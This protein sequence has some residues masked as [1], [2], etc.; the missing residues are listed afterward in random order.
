MTETEQVGLHTHNPPWW[1]QYCFYHFGRET[2][3]KIL[4][5]P[6]RPR[7][8]RVNPLRN[9][10]R[11]SLPLELRNYSGQLVE[12]DS[13]THLLTGSPSVLAKYFEIGLFQV[14]DFAS[15]LSVKAADPA[16]GES[17]L[18]LCAA[19]GRQTATLA[20]MRKH[21]GRINSVYCSGQC[22]A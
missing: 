8:V 1:V 17:V 4:S 9:R 19:P 22:M 12:A 15:Y 2:G 3:L 18:D 5:P 7:Y 10:G 21:R 16:P 20:S 13:G 6:A 11:T 14:Q